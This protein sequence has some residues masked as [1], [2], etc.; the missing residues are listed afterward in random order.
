MMISINGSGLMPRLRGAI[1]VILALATLTVVALPYNI[2][3]GSGQNMR[4]TQNVVLFEKFTGTWCSPCGAI[5]PN[6]SKIWEF[7]GSTKLAIVE[8]H[9]VWGRT[10]PYEIPAGVTRSNYYNVGSIGIP[11]ILTDG[12]YVTYGK[13]YNYT[14]MSEAINQSLA[15]TRHF[16]IGISGDLASG[17]VTVH[18]SQISPT[19]ATDL[20][21]RYAI[22]ESNLIYHAGTS[23][24]GWYN[25]TVRA[26]PAEDI[27]TLPLPVGG[28]D[29]VKTFTLSPSW[30]TQNLS[31]VAFLQ[32]D[33]SKQVLQSCFYGYGAATVYEFNAVLLFPGAVFVAIVSLI[34]FRRKNNI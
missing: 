28:S 34:A 33:S 23:P 27:I 12:T 6:V 7:Y 9:L 16:E 18:I 10:D 32:N 11:Y 24:G 8:Y 19:T 13:G 29:F 30:V 25:H 3:T 21:L 26:I 22:V 2:V 4:I 31:F 15:V 17:S 14:S 1:A 20:R 5:S